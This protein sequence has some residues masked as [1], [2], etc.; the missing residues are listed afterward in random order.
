MNLLRINLKNFCAAQSIE[1][2][3]TGLS[4]CSIIGKNGASKSTIFAYAPFFALFGKLR[5]GC[6][7]D[8]MV[9]TGTQDMSVSVDFDQNGEVYQVI[10]T[11]NLKGKGKSACEFQKKTAMGWESLSG[12]TIKETDAKIQ[13][14]LNLDADTFLASSLILQ[15]DVSNFSRKLPSER[16]SVLTSILGLDVYSTLQ[17]QAKAKAKA[18]ELKLEG[19]KQGLER[20]KINLDKLPDIAVELSTVNQQIT[21][22]ALDIKTKE[23][24]LS[25][26]QTEIKALEAKE[27]E[28]KQIQSQIE[29]LE[30]EINV[31]KA[32]IISLENRIDND[33]A[34]LQS[35]PEIMQKI[36]ELNELRQQIPALEAKATRLNE[37]QAELDGLEDEET[38][39]TDEEHALATKIFNLL[40]KLSIKS[41]LQQAVKQH[42]QLSAELKDYDI[43]QERCASLSEEIQVEKRQVDLLN[44]HIDTLQTALETNQKKTDILLNSGCIDSAKANCKF[45]QDA[46]KSRKRIPGIQTEIEQVAKDREPLIEQVG[47]LER[48]RDDLGYDK[49]YHANLKR[50]LESLQKK[51]EQ[52]NSL[53]GKE[54]LLHTLQGQKDGIAQR[55][56]TIND[57]GLNLQDDIQT[58]KNE[59]SS[60]SSFKA[61]ISELEPCEKQAEQIPQ[62]KANIESARD[63]IAK[64]EADISSRYQQCE[65]LR[66]RYG[67]LRSET[68]YALPGK[69]ID[70]ERMNGT[71]KSMQ[72]DLNALF[73]RQGALKTQYEGLLADQQKHAELSQ[74]IAP[75]AKELTRWETLVRAFS[76][77]GIPVLILENALPELERI[78]NDI[79]SQMSNGQHSLQFITQRDAK[80]KDSMIETLDIL[81]RDWA[82]TR[83][84]ESFSGG[85]QTRISLA[86]RFALSELL[87]NRAGS[88]VEFIVGDEILSDQSPEFR[89]MTIEAIKSMAGR[90]KKIL[91][92]SHI[93]EIQG[94]FDQ[95]ITIS[96]GGKVD[97]RFN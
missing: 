87:A 32:E 88:K 23:T 79:L 77:N 50:R 64:L 36:A 27:Q 5:P 96:E 59:T 83:P 71:L 60:L 4:L 85:E 2:D 84:F 55:I 56:N 7:L 67:D 33:Q 28:A 57:K 49:A 65:S 93:P 16:K 66:K 25:D 90:F 95:Q 42:D 75:Q 61:K 91:I 30:N 44:T 26:I 48:E 70:A 35:E 62:A 41:E 97:V 34:I 11:R 76:K 3:L 89:E 38:K 53:Q 52:Y 15:G 58:L 43:K 47:A 19:N 74:I 10:R 80:S 82:G 78:A 14:L 24:E 54:E 94:A 31:K 69:M 8:D 40:A 21:L 12:A 37:L 86:I 17:D 22:K 73:A 9:R 13:A 18:L 63:S 92:I 45:L 68:G 1:M 29:G 72:S 46:Q 51:V 81:V 20:L 6:S 39:L